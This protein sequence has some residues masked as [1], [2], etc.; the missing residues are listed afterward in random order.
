MDFILE[1]SD[2]LKLAP[3]DFAVVTEAEVEALAMLD[4]KPWVELNAKQ[5]KQFLGQPFEPGSAHLVLLRGCSE[6]ETNGAFAV[7]VRKAEVEIHWGQFGATGRPLRHRA[8]IARLP[9]LPSEVY[10]DGSIGD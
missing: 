3:E 5:A 2:R 4:K 9:V 1:R 7:Y 8:L 10:V 6:N